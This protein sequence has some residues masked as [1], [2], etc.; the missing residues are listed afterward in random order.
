MN[1]EYAAIE[2]EKNLTFYLSYDIHNFGVTYALPPP[3]PGEI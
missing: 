1:Q 3:S 2:S